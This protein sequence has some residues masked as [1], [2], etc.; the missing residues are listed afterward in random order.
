MSE[1][2]SSPTAP[3][4]PSVPTPT[5]AFFPYDL[6]PEYGWQYKQTSP[7]DS[8]LSKVEI[9]YTDILG[10]SQVDTHYPSSFYGLWDT[11]KKPKDTS[12]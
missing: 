11:K 10:E 3:P 12:S 2:K 5:I 8:L 4:I 1:Q 7:G 6:K 9:S